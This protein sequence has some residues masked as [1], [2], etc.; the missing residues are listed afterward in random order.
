MDLMPLT[1]AVKSSVQQQLHD[2]YSLVPR[3]PQYAAMIVTE[4]AIHDILK[5][6]QGVIV[7]LGAPP[8]ILAQ[9]SPAELSTYWTD[10]LRALVSHATLW[11]P[12]SVPDLVTQLAKDCASGVFQNYRNGQRNLAFSQKVPSGVQS[13]PEY[14]AAQGLKTFEYQWDRLF[15][16]ASTTPRFDLYRSNRVGLP[17][18]VQS[19]RSQSCV[20]NENEYLY[21]ERYV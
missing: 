21:P 3:V 7:E 5:I 8:Y 6:A 4:E 14:C 18:R 12:I 9:T 2:I 11:D 20:P 13:Y 15:Q 19:L 16:N 17:R 1:V 10:R